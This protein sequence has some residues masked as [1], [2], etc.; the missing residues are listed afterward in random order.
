ML[1]ISIRLVVM[2]LL[3][4]LI[5]I[6]GIFP[7]SF[8]APLLPFPSPCPSFPSPLSSFPFLSPSSLFPPSLLSLFSFHSS[9]PRS[10]P[11]PLILL[12]FYQAKVFTNFI[13]F[14]RPYFSLNW[15]LLL[16]LFISLTS[17]LTIIFFLQ[18]GVQFLFFF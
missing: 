16:F 3:S 11:F 14:Q 18:L 6:T 15:L 4:S 12:P 5:L 7:L 10:P 17:A 2:P 9:L 13:I 8:L 1:L